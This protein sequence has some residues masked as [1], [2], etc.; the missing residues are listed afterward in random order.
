MLCFPKIQMPESLGSWGNLGNKPTQAKIVVGTQ[1]LNVGKSK[2]E[3]PILL[4]GLFP[5]VSSSQPLL[6]CI[7]EEEATRSPFPLRGLRGNVPFLQ[8]FW[9]GHFPSTCTANSFLISN[10]FTLDKSSSL[11]W[12][13]LG[14][15]D[16]PHDVCKTW[17]TNWVFMSTEVTCSLACFSLNY[18]GNS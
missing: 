17:L 8:A 9:P 14:D 18:N 13:K 5:S 6:T 10:Q 4:M 12:C 16:H 1:A 3:R 2:T 15:R 7:V 11:S